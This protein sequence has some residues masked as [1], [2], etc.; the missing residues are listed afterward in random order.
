MGGGVENNNGGLYRI[1]IR[2]GNPVHHWPGGVP[3]WAFAVARSVPGVTATV[4]G[5]VVCADEASN[6][7]MEWV[8]TFYYEVAPGTLTYIGQIA[9]PVGKKVL[10][11]GVSD[12]S[13][14]VGRDSGFRVAETLPFSG[15]DGWAFTMSR[16]VADPS[17]QT[18]E[19]DGFAVC[20]NVAQ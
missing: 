11:G 20:A 8:R 1:V 3:R 15:G 2:D 14:W 17:G 10:G 4:R 16:A 18:T 6:P 13:K 9:C 19:L 12:E 5:W 7:G